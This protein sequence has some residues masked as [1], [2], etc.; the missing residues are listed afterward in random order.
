M[1]ERPEEAVQSSP[2]DPV[3]DAAAEPRRRGRRRATVVA[4]VLVAAAVVAGAG[5]TVVT[6]RQADRDAGAPVWKF[7]KAA[8]GADAGE[9]TGLAGM[10]VPYDDFSWLRGPDIRGLGSDASLSGWSAA[11]FRKEE[12]RDMPRTAR[13]KLEERI[14]G[15]AIKGMAVRS[16]RST[17]YGTVTREPAT[18]VNMQLVQMDR[19]A[20]RSG[21]AA[22]KELVEV[23]DA[24]RKGPKIE[25]H[26]EAYCFL[27]P[28]QE[29]T[30]LE[31]MVCSAASGD[32]LVSVTAHGTEPLDTE[33]VASLLG[34]QLD[35]IGGSGEAV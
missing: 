27:P 19:R 26:E 34:E 23:L 20:A 29:E 10:L 13:R 12:L 11:E 31:M 9:A 5:Y 24:F 18:T 32:V 8:D 17:R 21:V 7:P 33:G 4:S 30:D 15:Q 3:P 22:A 2:A 16:Y 25:G 35:R 14:D 28:K 6:V 1:S